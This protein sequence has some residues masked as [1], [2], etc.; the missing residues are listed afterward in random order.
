MLLP[1][2][3]ATS[4]T[5]YIH[6][7]NICLDLLFSTIT[8]CWLPLPKGESQL[9]F[10]LSSLLNILPNKQRMRMNSR[11]ARQNSRKEHDG[12]IKGDEREMGKKEG[13]RNAAANFLPSPPQNQQLILGSDSAKLISGRECESGEREETCGDFRNSSP[14]LHQVML[15]CTVWN[16]SHT[17]SAYLPDVTVWQLFQPTNPTV[18]WILQSVLPSYNLLDS[19]GTC[20]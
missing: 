5:F 3:I 6:S 1:R 12:D 18:Q 14:K 9:P 4:A 7:Y 15:C 8:C 19:L 17:T 13:R 10:L 2:H 11:R 20:F 16:C